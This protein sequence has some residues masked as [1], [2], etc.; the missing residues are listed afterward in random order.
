MH[1]LI[2]TL[3]ICCGREAATQ[4]NAPNLILMCCSQSTAVTD[5]RILALM[6]KYRTNITANTAIL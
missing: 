2:E 5:E 1:M 3:E 6:V 4:L